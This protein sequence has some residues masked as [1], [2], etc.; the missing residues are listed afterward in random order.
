MRRAQ[1]AHTTMTTPEAKELC[2]KF[3]SYVPTPPEVTIGIG[4]I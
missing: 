1:K 4:S 2:E 3:I